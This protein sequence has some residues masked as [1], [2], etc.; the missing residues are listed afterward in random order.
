MNVTFTV[1]SDLG[2]ILLETDDASEV[3]ELLDEAVYVTAT[4]NGK[5]V[6]AGDYL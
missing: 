1:T 4:L 6:D 5:E 3:Y 2:T